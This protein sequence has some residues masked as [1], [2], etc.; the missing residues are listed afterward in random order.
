[1]QKK[2]KQLTLLSLGLAVALVGASS[3]LA[4]PAQAS[5]HAQSAAGLGRAAG[6]AQADSH[7]PL[8]AAGAKANAEAHLSSARLKSCQN[9]QQAID[10][11]MARISDRGQK[12][13]NLFGTIATRVETF[14]TDKGKTLADYD[15]LV[16]DVNTQQTAAQ[17]A[18]SNI[19]SDSTGFSCD[20]SDP[21][22][23]VDTFKTSLK[24]EIAALKTYRTAVKNLIVGVK[25]VEGTSSSTASGGSQ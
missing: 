7:Q 10:N 9:R 21:K 3:V 17:T 4:L 8:Q 11:I 19:K 16:S 22:A 5:V 13:L 15:T 2:S 14:Y 20:S 25:S 18:V 12:Q 24:S 6:V 1:M 23:F